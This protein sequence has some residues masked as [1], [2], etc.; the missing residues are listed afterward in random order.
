MPLK[1]L[2]GTFVALGFVSC[3]YSDTGASDPSAIWAHR[4]Y[5][6][7]EDGMKDAI[8]EIQRGK[9]IIPLHSFWTEKKLHA[10]L[11]KRYGID[12]VDSR[13]WPKGYSTSY[14]Q[15]MRHAAANQFGSMWWIDSLEE[16]GIDTSI[17]AE[18]N[19]PAMDK[20]DPATS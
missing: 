2:I 9:I 14:N 8:S 3:R 11:K 17:K 4:D 6:Q 10:V 5:D 12:V 19:K 7:F 16:E 1:L 20:P 15:A 18:Q 13:E